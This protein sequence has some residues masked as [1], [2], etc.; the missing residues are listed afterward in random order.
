MKIN[1]SMEYE[2]EIS[3]ED[4]I[5]NGVK[6]YR[7]ALIRTEKAIKTW[8]RYAKWFE[9][10]IQEER[11]KYL[12]ISEWTA[13]GRVYDNLMKFLIKEKG[14]QKKRRDNLRNQTAKAIGYLKI[15]RK[16]QKM[17]KNEQRADELKK[18]INGT[19]ILEN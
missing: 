9:K 5:E 7:F 17:E 2:G 13:R 15:Y 19:I 10:E 14:E 11:N 18:L 12:K 8:L 1:K 3:K 6:L 4:S 16:L